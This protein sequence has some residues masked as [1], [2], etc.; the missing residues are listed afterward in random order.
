MPARERGQMGDDPEG[1][2]SDAEQHSHLLNGSVGGLRERGECDGGVQ[3][4]RPVHDSGVSL[5]DNLYLVRLCHYGSDRD[6]L[7]PSIYLNAD[8]QHQSRHDIRDDWIGQH[9]VRRDAGRQ[10]QHCRQ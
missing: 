10:C 3:H 8:H 9:G 4:D 1:A 6:A 5:G 7:E 2:S